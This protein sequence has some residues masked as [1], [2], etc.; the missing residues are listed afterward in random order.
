ME[1]EVKLD[2]KAE[3]EQ[4]DET[5]EVKEDEN[6]IP[7]YRFKEINESLRDARGEITKLKEKQESERKAEL[8]KQGEYKT[9]LD[10][11]KAELEKVTAKANAWN[12]YENT[13]RESLL[14][15]LPENDREIYGSLSLEKL[16]Q[17]IDRFSISKV[18]STK[19]G[20]TKPSTKPFTDMD[21]K[22]KR[23]NWSAILDKY[24]N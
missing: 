10:E 18:D 8:E 4:P 24:R 22:E 15:K 14:S 9:L 17:H 19:S 13:R 1:N 20:V 21:E 5:V 23:Q 11:T 12:D 7:Y 16:E 6:S 3:V 2:V